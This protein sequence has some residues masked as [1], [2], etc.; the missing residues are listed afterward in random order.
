[1]SKFSNLIFCISH[2]N[3]ATRLRCGGQ[4]NKGLAANLLAYWVQ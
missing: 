2:G 4:Y 3:V 1:M